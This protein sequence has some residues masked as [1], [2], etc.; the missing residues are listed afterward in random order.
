MKRIIVSYKNLEADVL[1]A[2]AKKFPDGYGDDDII[3]FRNH[4]N[5]LIEAVE[6]RIEQCIY[7]I[8]VSKQLVNNMEKIL[9][10]DDTL[11]E[12]DHLNNPHDLSA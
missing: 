2:L 5:E 11:G 7:L 1:M 8:K 12:I 4:K 9:E 6:L 10:S 3:Q